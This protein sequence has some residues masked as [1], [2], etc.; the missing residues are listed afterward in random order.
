MEYCRKHRTRV[1]NA[2]VF[3]YATLDFISISLG[4]GVP[5]SEMEDNFIHASQ[6]NFLVKNLIHK[7]MLKY[8][9]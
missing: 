2:T 3:T 9:F 4:I 7:S 5:I 8:A 6:H 1:R